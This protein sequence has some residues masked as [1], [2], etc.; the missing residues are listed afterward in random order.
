MIFQYKTTA[1][2]HKRTWTPTLSPNGLGRH[3]KVGKETQKGCSKVRNYFVDSY[4]IVDV[5]TK[6]KKSFYRQ[7]LSKLWPAAPPAV[8]I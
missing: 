1:L 4:I 3:I 8:A 6:L 7:V 2:K 5:Q